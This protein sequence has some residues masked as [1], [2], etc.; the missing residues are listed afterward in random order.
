[1]FLRNNSSAVKGV[2]QACR[3]AFTGVFLISAVINLL[4][5]TGPIFMLQVYDR[6]LA[7]NSVPTLVVL[8]CLALALYVFS[9]ALDLLRSRALTR[10]SMKVYTRLSDPALR[11]HAILPIV[12][13][14]KAAALQPGRDVDA[15]RRFLGSQGPAAIFDLPFMPLYFVILFLFHSTLGMLSLGGGVLIFLLVL[16]NEM[17]SREPARELNRASGAQSRLM[18]S[19][20]RN[21]EVVT[22]MG[23]LGRIQEQ[24]V[25]RVAAHCEAQQ[26]SADRSNFYSTIIKTLRLILQS[27]MLGLGAY[28]AIYQEISPGVMIASSIIMAR[29]LAPIE[30]AVSQW[31]SFVAARQASSRLSETLRQVP[32][33]NGAPGLPLPSEELRVDQ[34]A[35]TAP[36]EPVVLLQG[37]SFALK[38]GDGLG[39]IGHSGSGKTSLARALV[40]VWPVVSGSVRL[41]GSTLDQWVDG[42]RGRFI[43]YLPQDVELFDG[44]VA[45][46]ICRFSADPKLVDII[47]SAKL[48]GIHKMIAGLPEGYNSMVGEGGMRLSAGQRQ[49]IGL[50]RAV[51]GNPFLIVLDE[52]NS[53]LD[54][55]GERA[56][57]EAML[58]MRRRGSIVIVIAHRTSALAA[59]N[60]VL[61]IQNGKQ[62]QF[63]HRDSVLGNVSVLPVPGEKEVVRHAV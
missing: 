50:A 52:P 9:W 18:E 55:E 32:K 54:Q 13:G 46:N 39:V 61:V 57:T 34:L 43:G 5:L 27:A 26:V 20:R 35:T 63:G 31:P 53:N 7:S 44:T 21:A 17:S 37:A 19:T 56:L 29:A 6:V 40:G 25:E 16:A 11:A 2:L 23:M 51:Y 3:S 60:H 4:M 47:A 15:I 14:Q 1:M 45:E 28:L 36:G 48:A 41:D 30:Q 59:V 38:A 62:A 8:A 10:V 22:S 24:F 33:D 49:R 12:A 58:E 42:D